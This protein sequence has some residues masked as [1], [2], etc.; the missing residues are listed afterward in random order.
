MTGTELYRLQGMHIA[1]VD[2]HSVV[3]EGLR[4]CLENSGVEHVECFSNGG[5]LMAALGRCRFDIY[6]VDVELPGEDCSVLIDEIRGMD[7]G[8]KIVV[9]TMHE[10]PWV[11]SKITSKQVDAVVYKSASM[12]HL[13]DVVTSVAAGRQYFSANFRRLQSLMEVQNDVPTSRELE[14]LKNIASGRSTKNIATALFISENT[15]ENH[16][17]SLFR[18]FKVRNMAEL[19]VK[20]IA[21]GYINPKELM[22]E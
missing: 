20:A 21:Q 8:A 14:I 17:K 1:V 6:I 4:S 10:E 16:R 19:I 22:A 3:Q 9:N 13:L 11:V 7:K 2:D 18:K 12:E 5:Q 15:V